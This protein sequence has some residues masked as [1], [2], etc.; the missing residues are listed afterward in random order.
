LEKFIV[1]KIE[2]YKDIKNYGLKEPIIVNENGRILDGNHRCE[3][4]KSLG[5]KTIL[6]RKA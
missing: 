4:I 1:K 2:T 5:F 6:V 3:M